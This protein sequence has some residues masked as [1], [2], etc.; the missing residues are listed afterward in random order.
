MP[1]FKEYDSTTTALRQAQDADHDN[2]QRARDAHLFVNKAD[3]MWEPYWWEA[4][5]NRPRYTFDMTTPVID[6]ISGE[7]DQSDFVISVEPAGGEASKDLAKTADG[8]IRNIQNISNA[9]HVYNAAARAMITGGIDFVVAFK[10]TNH[11]GLRVSSDGEMIICADPMIFAGFPIWPMADSSSVL[12]GIPHF[13]ATFF[14][15]R[16]LVDPLS[17][18][19][20]ILLPPMFIVR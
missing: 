7:L 14:A 20:S 4:N 2:R 18:K 15:I 11:A 3:G 6:Q 8:L 17:I 5:A 16:L 13:L 9:Q 12:I 10:T 19:A 1:N